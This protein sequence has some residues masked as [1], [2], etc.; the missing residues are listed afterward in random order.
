VVPNPC[1]SPL[2][3]FFLV[4]KKGKEKEKGRPICDHDWGRRKEERG[5]GLTKTSVL[6]PHRG[7]QRKGEGLSPFPLPSP[8]R[9]K[10]G[11]KERRSWPSSWNSKRKKRP[12]GSGS[13]SVYLRKEKKETRL[14]GKKIGT[15]PANPFRVVGEGGKRERERAQSIVFFT[16]SSSPASTRKGGG[17]GGRGERTPSK[18]RIGLLP[19]VR[20][21]GGKKMC[22]VATWHIK[23]FDMGKKK[24]ELSQHQPVFFMKHLREKKRSKGNV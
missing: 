5:C 24:K 9:G 17:G 12:A 22:R 15:C 21:G 1:G 4:P 14:S 7:R 3:N 11:V 20:R 19:L 6:W 8:S 23:I 2:S 16:S 18:N 10:R 13:T